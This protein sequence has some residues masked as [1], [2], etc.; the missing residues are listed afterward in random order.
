MPS[1][2][3]SLRRVHLYLGLLLLPWMLVYAFST[4]MFNHGEHFRPYRADPQWRLLWE[5]DY[6]IAAPAVD[7]TAALQA[8]T[9]QL[10]ADHRMRGAFNVRRQGQRLSINVPNFWHPRRFAYDFSTKK[11]R[12]EERPTTPF[13]VL[14]RLHERT[15]YGRGGLNNLWAFFVDLFCLSTLAWIA[16]GLLLWWKIV[17][18]RRPGFLALGGGLATIALLALA[19]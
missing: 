5:K 9:Q 17:E 12:A 3:L 11:L 14:A 6:A 2:N 10:L 13:D 19:L 16:T 8:T 4:F 7:D 15:S 1:W 18:V